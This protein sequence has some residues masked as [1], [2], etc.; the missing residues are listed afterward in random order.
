MNAYISMEII[1]AEP[2]SLWD[3]TDKDLESVPRRTDRYRVPG[4]K[5]TYT[6]GYS[7]WIPKDQFEKLYK[8][9]K[10]LSFADALSLMKQGK[11][12]KRAG[13]TNKIMILKDEA[14]VY[15]YPMSESYFNNISNTLALSEDWEL[16]SV[17]NPR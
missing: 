15:V 1:K 13:W 14:F 6:N 10:K 5:I 4:F 16:V 2:M 17:S 12:V 3:W 9:K 11:A 7:N 8:P